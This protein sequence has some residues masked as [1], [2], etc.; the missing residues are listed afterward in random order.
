MDCCLGALIQWQIAEGFLINCEFDTKS[1]TAI[2]IIKRAVE[3]LLAM[4]RR[5]TRDEEFRAPD[6]REV[7]KAAPLGCDTTSTLLCETDCSAVKTKT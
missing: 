2:R 4:V 3:A 1:R 7:S 5:P 6:E